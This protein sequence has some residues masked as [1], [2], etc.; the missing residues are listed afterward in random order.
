MAPFYAEIIKREPNHRGKPRL[1]SVLA[2]LP[3]ALH[4]GFDGDG[5]PPKRG[6]EA[7]R[8]R[9]WEFPK[10]LTTPLPDGVAKLTK[11]V[12]NKGIADREAAKPVAP[13]VTSSGPTFEERYTAASTDTERI[14][15]MAREL[16]LLPAV[17][18]EV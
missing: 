12:F 6:K 1:V 5:T 13:Q 7:T 14:D 16:G 8:V 3:G 18:D 11:T 10:A 2:E 17:D 4:H 15:M 9:F